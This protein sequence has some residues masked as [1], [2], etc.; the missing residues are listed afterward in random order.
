MP[1]KTARRVKQ[2]KVKL[3]NARGNCSQDSGDESGGITQSEIPSRHSKPRLSEDNKKTNLNYLML[4]DLTPILEKSQCEDAEIDRL[5]EKAEDVYKNGDKKIFAQVLWRM[6]IVPFG[7]KN[8][9]DSVERTVNFFHSLITKLSQSEV[10][11]AENSDMSTLESNLPKDSLS[12]RILRLCEKF[13]DESRPQVRIR[14]VQTIVKICESCQT[15][16]EIDSNLKKKITSVLLLR[17]K[18]KNSV[19]RCEA[20]KGLCYFQG[21]QGCPV[22]S[23]MMKFIRVDQRPEV[24]QALVLSIVLDSDDYGDFIDR[25]TDLRPEV[26]RACIHQIREISLNS[27]TPTEREKIVN[28]GLSD[29][30][31]SVRSETVKLLRHWFK[32][33]GENPLTLLHKFDVY[34]NSKL[35]TKIFNVLFEEANDENWDVL[36]SNL[37]E[38]KFV[39]LDQISEAKFFLWWYLFYKFSSKPYYAEKL[40][41][42]ISAISS[43]CKSVIEKLETEH[44]DEDECMKIISLFL[45]IV[46]LI[47]VEEGGRVELD[48]MARTVFK[49]EF[50]S[51]YHMRELV[52]MIHKAH[53]NG[54]DDILLEII[55]DLLESSNSR[56]QIGDRAPQLNF[57]DEFRKTKLKVSEILHKKYRLQ[58]E[59]EELIKKTDYLEVHKIQKLIEAVEE[60]LAFAKEEL[61]KVENAANVYALDSEEPPQTQIEYSSDS[62]SFAFSA[63]FVH[64]KLVPKI[65]HYVLN[66][67]HAEVVKCIFREE[68]GLRLQ[69]LQIMTQVGFFTLEEAVHAMIACLQAVL[70]ETGD[71]KSVALQSIF[72]LVLK[73][74]L[75]SFEDPKILAV[76]SEGSDVLDEAQ[77]V[78]KLLTDLLTS[79]FKANNDVITFHIAIV[80]MLK[81]LIMGRHKATKIVATL[82]TFW[83]N[84]ANEGT[85]MYHDIGAGLSVYVQQSS[86]RAETVARALV[87]SVSKVVNASYCSSLRKVDPEKLMGFIT[88]QTDQKKLLNLSNPHIPHQIIAFDVLEE[89]RKRPSCPDNVYF[90]KALKGLSLRGISGEKLVQLKSLLKNA[91]K[92]VLRSIKLS[93]D[94]FGR[95]LDE[96]DPEIKA[97]SQMSDPGSSSSDYDPEDNDE[98]DMFQSALTTET[99]NDDVTM[100][101]VGNETS[102]KTVIR[103]TSSDEKTI[104]DD[105]SS[106][107]SNS[108]F[109]NES[110]RGTK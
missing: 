83:A 99:L 26:R 63:F 27:I 65:S 9:F 72:D 56:M 98:T 64:L 16:D 17:L 80:G 45:K 79:F 15:M 93:L 55:R 86:E 82:L 58:K 44:F 68:E 62:L 88:M 76:F 54:C 37:R 102:D 6:M 10:T 39:P 106:S 31:V 51:V 103:N 25:V 18:D 12:H 40:F 33:C 90:V 8:K 42:T 21:G 94:A 73:Y 3:P 13:H 5:L 4:K 59:K 49:F 85:K 30:S 53:P 84:S 46:L 67:Y 97:L 11:P 36:D 48:K 66:F 29:T 101:S 19:V 61:H 14:I 69:V 22:T 38:D 104:I 52:L 70:N 23:E 28:C 105:N 41:P 107:S 91:I 87:P 71:V 57:D 32:V 60:E 77:T 43:Y 81:L 50:L 95:Y 110:C 20:A 24:R 108:D 1:G 74:G 100:K 92:D 78:E 34:N 96:L 109:Q 2:P 47:P 75:N 35:C 7:E 89:I